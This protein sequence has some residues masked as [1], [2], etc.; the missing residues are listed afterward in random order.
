V[1]KIVTDGNYAEMIKE[2]LRIMSLSALSDAVGC[3]R[4]LPGCDEVL[5]ESA[6]AHIR[7]HRAEMAQWMRHEVDDFTPL[8]SDLIAR[9]WAELRVCDGVAHYRW[10]DCRASRFNLPQGYSLAFRVEQD[11]VSASL[12]DDRNPKYPDVVGRFLVNDAGCWVGRDFARL[13]PS[14]EL[15]VAYVLNKHQEFEATREAELNRRLGAVA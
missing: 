7:Q 5:V 1:S 15:A 2:G 9:A 11:G 3:M 8:D 12:V 10:V 13:M 4:V 6:R 14:P